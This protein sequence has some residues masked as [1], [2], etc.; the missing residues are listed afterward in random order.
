MERVQTTSPS[1]PVVAKV[2]VA[3]AVVF[4]VVLFASGAAITSFGD[5][6]AGLLF[7]LWVALPLLLLGWI[8]LFRTFPVAHVILLVI[9]IIGSISAAASPYG[10]GSTSA[11]GVLF[12]P[13]YLLVIFGVVGFILLCIK[14]HRD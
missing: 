10:S 2:S 13:S 4:A 9:G 11:L 7:S 6:V 5:V 14:S 3:L 8:K 1:S 12:F